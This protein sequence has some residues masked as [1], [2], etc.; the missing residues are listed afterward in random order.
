MDIQSVFT[1]IVV[2]K[3]TL[4]GVLPKNVYNSRRVSLIRKFSAYREQLQSI[5]VDSL[6]GAYIKATWDADTGEATFSLAFRQ[7]DSFTGMSLKSL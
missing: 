1:A 5:G 6:D 4:T 7:T 2:D 3:Q